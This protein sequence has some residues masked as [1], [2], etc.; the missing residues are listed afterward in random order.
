MALHSRPL[1]YPQPNEIIS[2]WVGPR[3]LIFASRQKTPEPS[4]FDIAHELGHLVL[5]HSS[6]EG[7][8]AQQEKEA[9]DFA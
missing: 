8:N 7:D 5:H 1:N 2:A 9:D 3:P 6:T 4:R